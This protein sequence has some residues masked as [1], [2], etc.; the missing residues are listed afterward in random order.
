MLKSPYF[1]VGVATGALAVMLL[2]LA[3]KSFAQVVP[4]GPEKQITSALTNIGEKL[5]AD[6]TAKSPNGAVAVRLFV[7]PT[8]RTWTLLILPEAGKACIGA[9]G[10]G[11]A[12]ARLS[13]SDA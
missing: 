9:V 12:P 2:L 11:F 4:C 8:K 10:E 1:I 5:F 13:G 7:H 3:P 6:A